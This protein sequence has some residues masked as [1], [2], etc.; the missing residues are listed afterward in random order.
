MGYKKE[1]EAKADF[2]EIYTEP[3]PHDYLTTMG[4]CG[5]RIAENARPFIISAAELLLEMNGEAL[6][7]Q[8]LDVGCSYGIGAASIKYGCS[9]DEIISFY[10][11]RAPKEYSSCCDVTRMWLNVVPPVYNIRCVGVDSSAPAID[12]AINAGLLDGGIA[13]DF[14]SNDNSPDENDISWFRSCNLLIGTGS[15]GYVTERTLSKILSH[16]GEDHPADFGPCAV[17]T[18][19]RMF[20]K[21]PIKSVFESFGYRFEPVPGI[22]LPQRKFV[23]ENEKKGVVDVLN[24]RGVDTVDLEDNGTLLAELFIAARPEQFELLLK[25]VSNTES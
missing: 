5:Y 17:V 7:V 20:D 9:I 15:I 8:M 23:D 1:N 12:F 24:K 19:L 14:E 16:L 3:T 21:E 6:P 22:Y 10:S 11:S 25:K 4:E 18:I 2:D 13:K